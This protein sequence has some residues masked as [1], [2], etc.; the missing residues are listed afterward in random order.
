MLIPE[1]RPISGVGYQISG[2]D[3]CNPIF[4]RKKNLMVFDI[5]MRN[6][7]RKRLSLGLPEV[8]ASS[9]ASRPLEHP[10]LGNK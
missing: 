8:A 3:I 9:V 6:A 1:K 10:F 5:S 7:F 2:S 4:S